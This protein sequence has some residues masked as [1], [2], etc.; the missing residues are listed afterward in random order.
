MK[1]TTPRHALYLFILLSCCLNAAFLHADAPKQDEIQLSLSSEWGKPA[2]CQ[3]A[4]INKAS[5]WRYVR[6][7]ATLIVTKT[8]CAQ[9]KPVSQQDVDAYNTPEALETKAIMISHKGVPAMLR[10]HASPKGVN[11]RT[12]QMV[13]GGVH[14]ELQLGIDRSAPHDI[15]FGLE[16]E[17]VETINRFQP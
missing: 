2:Y 11:L 6:K 13:A 1:T 3:Y 15:A 14:Y 17:F 9:C 4:A 5:E 16:L 7:Y 12:F 8:E 10:F